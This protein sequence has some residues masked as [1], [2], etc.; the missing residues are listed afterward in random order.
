MANLGGGTVGS[1]GQPEP[2][3]SPLWPAA[4]QLEG[5]VISWLAPAFGMGG[6]HLVPGSSVA[7]LTA[8]WAARD[9]TGAHRV[10]ASSAAHLSVAKAAHLLGLDLVE[11]PVD[12]R[13]RMRADLLPGDLTRSV[14]VLTAGT[15][16]TGA[17]DPLDAGDGAAWRHVDAAWAGPLRLSAHAG[18]LAG[19]E[20]ADSVAVSAHEWLYQPKESALVFFADPDTAHQALSFG[21]GY[22][23]APNVGLLGSH[24]NAALPLAATSLSWG[25]SGAAGRIEADMATAEVLAR[26]VADH[27]ARQLWAQPVTGV[28][29]WRP[30]ARDPA[31][32]VARTLRRGARSAVRLSRHASRRRL[33][34]TDRNWTARAVA[35]RSRSTAVR[36]RPRRRYAHSSDDAR[37]PGR[38]PMNPTRPR[39]EQVCVVTGGTSGLGAAMAASLARL[40][41]T[42][43][44]AGRS[45]DRCRSAARRLAH[46]T[47]GVVS[48]IC[49]DVT[50]ERAVENLMATV[51]HDH[52]HIDVL[53]TSAG[54]QARG[55][56]EQLDPATLRACLDVNVVG[57]WL[58]ARSAAPVMRASGYG[59]IVTLA[60]ALGLVGAAGR[61]GYAASKGA[62][63]QLTRSLAVEL[64]PDGI[65]VNALA[66][67]P[68]R[69]P[70]NDD[71]DD[72]PHVQRFLATE[73]PMR[74]WAHPSEIEP[75]LTM[76]TSPE[77]TYLTGTVIPVDGGW[78][79]H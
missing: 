50:D 72:D 43:V 77:A 49:C 39:T 76:L 62:V 74:R 14:V 79:A 68:F 46:D 40:G 66:P 32:N 17:V 78:T 47:G 6:G 52:G 64:A 8:L 16:S 63:I 45:E 12:D 56:L 2:V 13:Q 7:N 33:V 28:V 69:T 25:R 29:N 24:G 75:A 35:D 37:H 42:V 3:A 51:A 21:G 41:S 71:T 67:G 30:A 26:L 44:V 65:T 15:V 54:I 48:G 1:G 11:V 22:L 60:S 36:P 4:R 61:G 20:T 70:L 38:R 73:I 34:A 5:L 57:T 10:V 59:R 18:L 55:T 27:P 31:D 53:V 19:I 9:L 23:A 58:A